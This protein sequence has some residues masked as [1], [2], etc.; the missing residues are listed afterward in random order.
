MDFKKDK[1]TFFQL[2]L[3]ILPFMVFT[4]EIISIGMKKFGKSLFPE[5]AYIQYS[6]LTSNIVNGIRFL[7]PDSKSIDKKNIYI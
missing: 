4:I 2:T 7:D 1:K 5:R 6:H 3:L